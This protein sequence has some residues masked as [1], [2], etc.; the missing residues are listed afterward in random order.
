MVE[1][2]GLFSSRL[3]KTLQQLPFLGEESYQSYYGYTEACCKT[4]CQG[5][6]IK[7]EA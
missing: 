2:F 5:S 4:F 7:P 3:D 1:V 6:N